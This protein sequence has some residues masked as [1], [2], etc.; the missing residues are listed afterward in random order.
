MLPDRS[1]TGDPQLSIVLAIYNE[2]PSLPELFRRIRAADLPPW[3]IIAVDDGSTDG[4]REFLV[5]AARDDPRVR[6]IFHDGKQTTLRA[7]T[8]ALGAARGHYA[9]IMDSDLQHPPEL[10]GPMVARLDAGAALVI[11]SRYRHGGTPGPRSP[12]RA[13]ISRGAELLTK[14]L[15]AESRGVADPVSGYFA[16]RRELYVPLDP[17]Y[18]GYK[19]LLFVLVMSRGRGVEEVGFHFEP[20]SEGASK[21]TQGLAFVRVFLIELLLARRLAARL[22]GTNRRALATAESGS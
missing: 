7:Q 15:L 10:L 16:F 1:R 17:G 22:R 11:A 20:R 18:R 6:T 8:L 9:V 12:M 14:L 4:S 19:L 21:V 2:R 5:E 13:V 3:E